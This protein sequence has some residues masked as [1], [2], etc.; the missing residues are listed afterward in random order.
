MLKKAKKIKA[1]SKY[2]LQTLKGDIKKIKTDS[3][4]LKRDAETL[5]NDVKD[6]K[7]DNALTRLEM[8]FMEQRIDEKNK[9]YKDEILDGL[10]EVMGELQTMR[11]E[12]AAG[13]KILGDH[14][15]RITKLESSLV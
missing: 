14:E 11:E 12:N 13:A 6:L 3:R 1:S 9:R 7:S 4:D 15:G 10:D 5:K 2:D 8:K